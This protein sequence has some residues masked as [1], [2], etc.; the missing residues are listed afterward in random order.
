MMVLHREAAYRIELV[1]KL[2]A[3]FRRSRHRGIFPTMIQVQTANRCNGRCT[4]CPYEATVAQQSKTWM[5]ES[6]FRSIVTEAAKWTTDVPRTLILTLQN[7]PFLDPRLEE[8]VLKAKELLPKGWKTEITSN[9]T[10]IDQDRLESLL[11]SPPDL[12]NISIN[13][14][15][16]STYNEIAPGFDFGQ[17]VA[18]VERI[19]ENSK[20]NLMLRF[21]R[22]KANAAEYRRFKRKWRRLPIHSY[23]ANNRAGSLQDHQHASLSFPALSV[24]FLR[25][26]AQLAFP[27]C[28]L[29]FAQTNV[30]AEGKVLLCCN[31][32]ENEAVMGT[33]N[34]SSLYEIFNSPRY[35]AIR[36]NALEGHYEGICRKCSLRDEW[37]A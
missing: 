28:P 15:T 23:L 13:A 3:N 27:A 20:L 25:R 35:R 16:E 34:S 22:Q 12:L 17:T 32:Y 21:V 31:D 26:A 10:L 8:F 14:A 36:A 4:M 11:V 9:G 2:R 6:L 1:R 7:E 37:L 30:T 19:V 29:L 18:N 33:L 24:F 5:A